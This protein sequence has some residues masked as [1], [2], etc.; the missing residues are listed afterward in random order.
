MK[1]AVKKLIILTAL[2][3]MIINAQAAQLAIVI[4][5]MGYRSKEDAAILA[6]PKAISV[7]IIPSAPN[8]KDINH[9]AKQQ[10]RD[11]L[12]HLPMQALG[13]HSIET[14]ALKLGMDQGQVNNRIQTAKKIIPDAIGLNNHMGSAATA[15]A[16][17]MHKLMKELKQQNLFFLDSRTI[18]RS[19]AGKIAKEQGIPSLDRHIFLD[20]SN[21]FSDVSHQFQSAIRYAQKYGM[22][23]V[24][25][26]PR[27]NTIAVL[28]SG[29]KNLPKDIQLIGIGNLWRNE[30]VV[31]I[32]PFIFLFD[33][34]P[35]PT[36]VEPFKRIS[37][38]RG[39]PE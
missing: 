29:L 23:I 14:G 3:T 17:L 27:K 1:T 13:H 18:G 9:K 34:K 28:Q 38:L 4:D 6:L 12:I 2:Y 22:A 8:A 19:V 33:G 35:A 16:D 5:D 31:P 24:I 15:D 10:N 39:I 30:K 32:K 36:S 25:G 7:A 26:H 11:I 37:L 21:E 20:D